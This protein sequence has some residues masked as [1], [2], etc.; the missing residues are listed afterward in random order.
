MNVFNLC[1]SKEY[2]M[3]RLLLII[4]IFTLALGVFAFPAAAQDNPDFTALAQYFPT[5]APV[6]ASFRTD[7]AFVQTLDGLAAKLGS[8]MPGGAM[9]GSLQAALDQVASEVKPGGTFA[10]TIRPWLG[11]LAAIGIYTVED[12]GNVPPLTIAI[13]ITDQAKAETFFDALPNADRYTRSEG[14]GFTLYTPNSNVSSDPYFIFRS[15]VVLITGDQALAD[16]GGS[17]AKS[18]AQSDAFNT[19]I[20]LLPAPQYSGIVYMDTPA[21]LNKS[22]QDQRSFGQ[23]D[24]A[25]MDLFSSMLNALEP[26]AVGLT[27]LSDNTVAID[28]AS[29]LNAD[30]VTSFDLSTNA[31][32]V[33]S[34]FAQYIPSGTPLVIQSTNLYE[35]YQRAI[36][37]L[38]AVAADMPKDSNAGDVNTAI[39]GLNFIVRGLTGL[40]TEDALGW[41]TG[42][43]ALYLKVSP[44][45]S[46]APN[47][48]EVPTS[49]PFD[50]GI[51]FQVTDANAAQTLYAGLSDSLS[52][53]AAQNATVTSETLASGT[54]ALVLTFDGSDM[55]FPV[56]LLIA[57][58]DS[59]FVIGTRRMVEAAINPQNGLD[60]DATYIEADATV[61]DNA[62]AVMY[63]AGNG[64]QPI[65]RGLLNSSSTSDQRDGANLKSLL[66]LIRSMTMSTANLPDNSGSLARFV[67]T[68]PQ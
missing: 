27:M 6:Y 45:F 3:K 65:A 38:R 56:E 13:A 17:I 31:Q 20:G 8:M 32:P 53:F 66:G 15:D 34:A 47:F 24:A 43:Y 40:P 21:V 67:W 55:P 5:D 22:L 35:S 48:D 57:K 50:F 51:A 29:P 2:L 4:G 49:L 16:S 25:M 64:F 60:N 18:L 42:D 7:D 19:A 36:A 54:D 37:N 39:F 41:M 26:Q 44:A 46:D 14:D 52:T 33:D 59:V 9:P 10:D 30:A 12:T 68:L 23:Q 28:V 63:L 62:D 1:C 61:L 11:D 58:N